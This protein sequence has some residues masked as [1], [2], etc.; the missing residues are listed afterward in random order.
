MKKRFKNAK[1]ISIGVCIVLNSKNTHLTDAFVAKS[2]LMKTGG[3]WKRSY[4]SVKIKQ[5][6]WTEDKDKIGLLDC[7][8]FELLNII[9]II[10]KC[11]FIYQNKVHGVKPMVIFWTHFIR[12]LL[13]T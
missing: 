7:R 9:S 6:K 5:F 8:H 10:V 4:K 2:L 1:E 11:L 12:F 13:K 3:N